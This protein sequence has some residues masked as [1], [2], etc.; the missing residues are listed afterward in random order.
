[1]LSQYPIATELLSFYRIAIQGNLLELQKAALENMH[2]SQMI[3]FDN[4]EEAR[5]VNDP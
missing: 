2:Y 5:Y 1:V 4:A 3:R